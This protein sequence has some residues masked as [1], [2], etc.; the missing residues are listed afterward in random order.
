MARSLHRAGLMSLR[1]PLSILQVAAPAPTGGLESVLSELTG[2][3]AQR[4]HRVGLLAVV[5]RSGASDPLLASIARRG[6]EVLPLPLP[7]RAYLAERRAIRRV[8]A[9]WRPDVVHT[10]G[11]RP[12]LVSGRLA[13][14]AGVPWITTLHGFTGGGPKNRLY[15]W[16]QRRAARHASAAIAVSRGI[17]GRLL[18][19]GVPPIRLVCLPNAWAPRPTYTREEARRRLGIGAEARAIGWVGRLSEEKGPD[20]FLEMLAQVPGGNVHAVVIGD[21]PARPALSEL[22][23]RL[24][25]ERRV[26]WVGMV[27]EA[28][29][30]LPAFD[31]WV[32][33][34]RTEGTP[35]TLLE[36]MAARV[37]IV[38]TAVGG[39]PEVVS[40]AEAWLVPSGSAA[41]LAGAVVEALAEP[42]RAARLVEAAR[43]RLEESFATEPWLTTHEALYRDCVASAPRR[44]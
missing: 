16:L 28:F 41:A 18:G 2:G 9:E 31:V 27:P 43:T 42:E 35:I 12:D 4:G 17:Q 38:A 5:D 36:A 29:R 39:V 7:G 10:H 25:L 37:P 44:S 33:S 34:S 13:L 22:V 19:A 11:Y 21:G 40:A 1:P 24:G 15:E 3:L 8:L 14:R 30:L 6:V 26:T 32:L 20:I 23:L